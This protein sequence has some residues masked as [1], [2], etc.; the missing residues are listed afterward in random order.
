MG[1]EEGSWLVCSP[2]DT[3]CHK[4]T[5]KILSLIFNHL[6]SIL[7]LFFPGWRW[8]CPR[9]RFVYHRRNTL[10]SDWHAVDHRAWSLQDSRIC[11]HSSGV[12]CS[13]IAECTE[14]KSG[15]FF[16]STKNL[17]RCL[18]LPFQFIV[19][20]FN[21]PKSVWIIILLRLGPFPREIVQFIA[22]LS[23]LSEVFFPRNIFKT[24][25]FL[26]E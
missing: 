3:A 23:Q 8:L 18:T 6:F 10:L 12:L 19:Y 17:H 25:Y 4:S 5:S 20:H 15:F 24:A 14:R 1:N 9:T 22:G 21:R 16:K 13:S 2:K 7:M 26:P 11:W